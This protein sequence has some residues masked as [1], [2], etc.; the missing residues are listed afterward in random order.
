MEY[1]KCFQSLGTGAPRAS[2]SGVP[3]SALAAPDQRR[4]MV[5]F[6]ETLTP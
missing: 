4:L 6:A 3:A 2:A 5:A 1:D